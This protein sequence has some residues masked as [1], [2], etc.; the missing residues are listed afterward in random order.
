[1]QKA[2]EAG[3]HAVA[4]GIQRHILQ[5]FTSGLERCRKGHEQGTNEDAEEESRDDERSQNTGL[6]NL[7][8]ESQGF[9][10]GPEHL[11]QVTSAGT[12]PMMA[13]HQQYPRISIFDDG[14]LSG[15]FL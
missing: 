10:K 14:G 5:E 4:G 15:M 2:Q 13:D 11:G 7:S 6:P 9:H 1:M 8:D 12:T 3:A